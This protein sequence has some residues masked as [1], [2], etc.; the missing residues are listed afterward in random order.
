MFQKLATLLAGFAVER[1]EQQRRPD[2][3][4]RHAAAATAVQVR[5]G[6]RQWVSLGQY[7][8]WRPVSCGIL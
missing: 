4:R 7:S 3:G 2:P 6:T 8:V 1:Q 5:E